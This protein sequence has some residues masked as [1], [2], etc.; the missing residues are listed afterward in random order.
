TNN[1]LNNVGMDYD[2]TVYGDGV[3]E[4]STGA[5]RYNGTAWSGTYQGG[6]STEYSYLPYASHPWF[7]RGA[8]FVYTSIVGLGSFSHMNGGTHSSISFRPVVSSLQ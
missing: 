6:W 2:A 5:Y 1:L 3:Y 4:T 7:G 8:I